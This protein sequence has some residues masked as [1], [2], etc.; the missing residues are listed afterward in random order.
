MPNIREAL[1]FTVADSPDA[2]LQMTADMRRIWVS[3]G[4]YGE[5]RRWLNLALDAASPEPT[6]Q[7]IRS[8][9]AMVEIAFWQ[10]DLPAIETW[11]VEARRLLQVIDDPTT[12]SLIDIVDGLYALVCG[13]IERARGC[14]E[15][16]VVAATDDLEAQVTS[17]WVMGL[18]VAVSG[19]IED[20][21]AW[22]EKGRDLADASDDYSLRSDAKLFVALGRW[23]NGELE[24]AQ[25]LLQQSLQLALPVNDV[26]AVAQCLEIMAWVA[27][28]SH[29]AREAVALMAAAVAV[30]GAD[31]GTPV[32]VFS[33]IGQFH[34]GCE[35]RARELLTAA[36]F[37]KASSQGALLDF[38][39]AVYRRLGLTSSR[40]LR[41]L[42]EQSK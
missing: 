5:G 11:V 34:N 12:R 18:V 27:E 42:V 19:D 16:A 40:D 30:S 26:W 1:R 4:M 6:L 31:S 23:A 3:R 9:S 21:L 32:L 7:R 35:R 29:D 41:L 8:V 15:S 24:S 10:G 25:Q 2:A 38:D 36:E 13:E 14:A 17:R 20:A 39:Q 33:E 37:E 28:S 22:F